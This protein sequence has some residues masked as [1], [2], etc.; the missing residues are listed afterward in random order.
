MEHLAVGP[1]AFTLGV[2]VNLLDGDLGK[3][4]DLM[5]ASAAA[6]LPHEV[7]ADLVNGDIR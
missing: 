1:L 3:P 7:A 6:A 5:S 2:Y 4:L